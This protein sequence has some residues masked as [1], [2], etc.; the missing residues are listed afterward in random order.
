MSGAAWWA[1]IPATSACRPVGPRRPIGDYVPHF[2][3]TG[4]TALRVANID[5]RQL[6][7][8]RRDRGED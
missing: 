2:L 4:A 5:G 3:R 7:R 8:M 1:T 6:M